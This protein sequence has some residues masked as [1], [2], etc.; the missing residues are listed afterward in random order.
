L[1]QIVRSLKDHPD[2]KV[3]LEGHA[4]NAEKNAQEIS[5]ARAAALKDYL[6][7]KGISADRISVEG[8]GSSTPIAD[9]GTAAGRNKNRRVEIKVTY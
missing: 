3:K 7:S 4:D 2:V 1:S 5:E 8:F 9:N 6:V